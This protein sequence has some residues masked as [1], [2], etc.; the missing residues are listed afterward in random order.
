MSILNTDNTGS[1]F[2][3][4]TARSPSA[5]V[6][7][8]VLLQDVSV[9]TTSQDLRSLANYI[10][11]FVTNLISSYP[12]SLVGLATFDGT[13]SNYR[14]WSSLTGDSDSLKS[15]INSLILNPNSVASYSSSLEA[16]VSASK[17]SFG[18]RD[19]SFKTVVVLTSKTFNP[20]GL[21]ASA[22]RTSISQ[23]SVNPLFLVKTTGTSPY[24]SLV[25]TLK[26]GRTNTLST[27]QTNWYTQV[28]LELRNLLTQYVAV[29]TNDPYGFFQLG[30]AKTIA[31]GASASLS[32]QFAFNSSLDKNSF[33]VFPT[34]SVAPIGWQSSKV[35]LNWNR[36]PVSTSSTFTTIQD[37]PFNFNITSEDADNN[38]LTVTFPSLPSQ[39]TLYLN[40][41][42]VVKQG[43]TYDVSALSLTF[44]NTLYWS[45]TTSFTFQTGDGCDLSNIATVT[46]IVKAIN[47]P[48]VGKSFPVTVAEKNN[49]SISFAE[50]V[51]DVEDA[52]STLAIYISDVSGIS[53]GNL[54]DSNGQVVKSGSKLSGQTAKFVPPNIY[55]NGNVVFKY[56]VVDSN[57]SASNTYTVTVTV[58]PVN[59]PPVLSTSSSVLSC[60]IG[61][62]CATTFSINDPD[63]DDV[64]TATVLSYNVTSKQEFVA[65]YGSNKVNV[66]A[67][68]LFTTLPFLLPSY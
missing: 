46:F 47:Y 41:G 48:P 58:T 51:S 15:Y 42:T 59:D 52:S 29:A 64:E 4:F 13:P 24:T 34:V 50:W 1:V 30:D 38:I 31:T 12:G 25:N 6:I 3:N 35:L 49:A 7:D 22:F 62:P 40:D 54:Y 9:G 39:G 57:N 18:W 37:T 10:S 14:K 17:D 32:V 36:R 27:D 19:T 23:G 33:A 63:L 60:K 45:G 20:S 21:S 44:N 53:S 8:L 5:P 61:E 55:W 56:Y 43:T 26:F 16:S 2:T 11:L 67:G 68:N 66:A 65:I 28:S